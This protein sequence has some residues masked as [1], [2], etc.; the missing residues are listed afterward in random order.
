MSNAKRQSRARTPEQRENEMVALATDLA[1][2][3]LSQG[4]ASAQ[5]I[6]HYLRLATSREALEK[7]KL[8]ATIV[9][10]EAKTESLESAARMT[11]TVAEAIEAFKSYQPEDG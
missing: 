7:K 10:L 4:T 5:V 6:T 8:E 3:Q 1:E 2:R 9:N 11:E